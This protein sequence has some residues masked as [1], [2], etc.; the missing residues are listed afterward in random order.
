MYSK[1]KTDYKNKRTSKPTFLNF[2]IES[3]SECVTTNAFK[4]CQKR[5][6]NRCKGHKIKLNS[7]RRFKNETNITAY[8]NW[9]KC[10]MICYSIVIKLSS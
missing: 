2:I 6:T 10:G 5:L 3:K 7:W 8:Y 4:A 1:N 9:L